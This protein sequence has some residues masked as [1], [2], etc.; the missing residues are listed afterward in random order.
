MHENPEYLS[1]QL[2]TYLGNKRKLLPYLGQ[3]MAQVQARLG[4]RR[5]AVA[6]LFSGTGVVARLSKGYAQR[7][8]VN[9][10][11]RYSEITN[12]CYLANR[13]EVPLAALHEA[14]A[15]VHAH[16]VA[17]LKM[18]IITQLYAP[19]DD[20]HIREGERVFYTRRNAMYLDT[21]RQLIA[22]YPQALQPFLLAPLLAKASVHAN[23]S[24]VFKGFYKSKDGV[25]QFGGQGRHALSRIVADI[26]LPMPIFSQYDSDVTVTREDANALAGRLPQMDLVYLDPP[27][28]QHPYGSN[29]FMLNMLADY[30]PP[31]AMSAVSG[32]PKDWNR[33]V[34]NDKMKAEDALFALV[35]ALPASHIM[36]SYNCE[37]FIAHT[38]FLTRLQNY[39]H[40]Q[41]VEIPYNTFRG[42]RNLAARAKH[43]TE[44]IYIVE[45]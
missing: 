12:Q 18:G 24:G 43:V 10:L 25:G 45:K 14:V 7:L 31:A 21:A 39:R 5:L 28:N 29:Y 33:S 34:Y 22:A 1:Q 36:I 37:G 26:A 11:E 20:A 9:D 27:Y 15:Q 41:V 44:F 38:R 8:W 16:A 23:T 6:D 17:D 4:G 32:I 2:I 35:D 40:H 13:G 42:S 3:G 30:A 19:Q